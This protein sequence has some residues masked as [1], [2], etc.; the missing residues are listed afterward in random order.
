MINYF[1]DWPLPIADFYA[2]P[3]TLTDLDNTSTMINQSI[4]ASSYLWEF[5]DDSGIFTEEEPVHAF[6]T[7]N[8]ANY[9][10][11][12]IAVTDYGCT[13]TTTRIV[14]LNETQI[15]YVPNAFTPDGNEYNQN[16]LP[17]ITA[18]FD[19][20]D[21]TCYIFDRWGELIWENHN[22]L[23]GWDGRRLNGQA[24][25]DGVYIWRIILKSPYKDDRKAYTGH[26]TLLR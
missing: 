21:F 3:S 24:I 13:D 19:P 7:T 23:A 20:Y 6:P 9:V 4:G 26:V 22:H 18:D 10:V 12:L 25:E 11:T 16:W 15:I 1:C 8:S 14:I 5:G 2:L 17:I